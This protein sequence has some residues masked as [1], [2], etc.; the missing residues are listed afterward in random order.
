MS[1]TKRRMILVLGSMG[2]AVVWDLAAA[3]L[4]WGPWA[5]F[6]MTAVLVLI[7]CAYALRTTDMVIVRLLYFGLMVGFGELVADHWAVEVSQTLVY[8]DWGPQIWASPLYMPFSWIIVIAQLGYL[9][10]WM[11]C[12][13][14]FLVAILGATLMGAL[15]IPLYEWLAAQ[16][17][18]WTYQNCWMILG[19]TPVY[20]IAGEAALTMVLPLIVW[21]VE[22]VPWKRIALLGVVQS[23]WVYAISARL[24][25]ALIG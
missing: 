22:Q 2:L 12:R 24:C 13:W 14:G 6:V 11:S 21:R 3:L 15:N 19:H 4:H 10:Y 23:L 1:D 7:F 5:A 25:Y 16:A 20:V 17:G 8:S 18:F 9:A